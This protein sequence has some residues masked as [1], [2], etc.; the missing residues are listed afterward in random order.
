MHVNDLAPTITFWSEI[1]EHYSKAFC[2]SDQKKLCIPALPDTLTGL[3]ILL[4]VRELTLLYLSETSPWKYTIYFFS[5]LVISI[6]DVNMSFDISMTILCCIAEFVHQCL[7]SINIFS[8]AES[9]KCLQIK[10]HLLPCGHWF[11]VS[12][13]IGK[14]STKCKSRGE[15]SKRNGL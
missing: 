8:C 3:L 13:G 11:S 5:T 2:I 6:F 10:G 12:F 7:P 4:L 1:L 15:R 14:R 9:S